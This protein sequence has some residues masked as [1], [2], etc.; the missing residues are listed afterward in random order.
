MS[1]QPANSRGKSQR[2]YFVFIALVSYRSHA[3][4]VAVDCKGA[5][6]GL[7]FAFIDHVEDKRVVLIHLS[8]GMDAQVVFQGE[9]VA[10]EEQ[11]VLR[12]VFL[13]VKNNPGIK[14]K[15]VAEDIQSEWRYSDR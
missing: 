1:V 6:V 9:R 12:E 11:G 4:V 13:I 7:G 8:C 2:K 15:Q 14:I 3:D 10:G 5:L